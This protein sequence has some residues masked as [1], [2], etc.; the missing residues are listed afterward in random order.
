[1]EVELNLR[2]R[3]VDSEALDLAVEIVD[4]SAP[5]LQDKVEA[6]VTNLDMIAQA[7]GEQQGWLDIGLERIS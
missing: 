6:V 3:V 5:T 7:R 2:F 4:V 1:M